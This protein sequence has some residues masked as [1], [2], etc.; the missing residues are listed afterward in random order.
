M[1]FKI[2]QE[3]L[4]GGQKQRC[5]LARALLAEAPSACCPSVFYASTLR[6]AAFGPR[7]TTLRRLSGVAP[8]LDEATSA[9]DGS[10]ERAVQEAMQEARVGRTTVTVAHR[11]STIRGADQIFVLNNGAWARSHL[12]GEWPRVGAVAWG[13]QSETGGRTWDRDVERALRLV[14]GL[15]KGL[16]HW[17]LRE[18]SGARHLQRAH[19]ARRELYEVV[20]KLM[21]WARALESPLEDV[22]GITFG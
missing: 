7:F 9:L 20:Q 14:T 21:R 11:L 5:A 10:T 2:P 1:A 12:G 18:V 16:G 22:F 6:S 19:G 15:R 8:R 3:K 17:I 4:S 13:R